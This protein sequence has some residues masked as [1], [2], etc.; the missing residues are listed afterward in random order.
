MS[1]QEYINMFVLI[2]CEHNVCVCAK[3]YVYEDK[4]QIEMFYF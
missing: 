1:T 3:I 2:Y 4:Y